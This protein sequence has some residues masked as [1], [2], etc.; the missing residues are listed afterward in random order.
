MYKIFAKDYRVYFFDR[1]EIVKEGL[2]N[3]DLA[4]DIYNAMQALNIKSADV[5]G[6]SQGGMI[7]MALTLEHPKVVNKLVLGV[8]ASRVNEN[9]KNVV[10]K[11]VDCANKGDYITINKD[12]FSLLV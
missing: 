9:L 5:F 8:T 2:T 11:W 4:E 12:T 6:V 3:W 1:R 7:A 10:E